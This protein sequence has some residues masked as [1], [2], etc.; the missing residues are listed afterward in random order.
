MGGDCCCCGVVQC[1]R[2]REVHSE[3][4]LQGVAQLHGACVSESHSRA[5]QFTFERSLR[6]MSVGKSGLQNSLQM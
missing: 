4:V 2:S 3:A 5:V 1:H 6:N